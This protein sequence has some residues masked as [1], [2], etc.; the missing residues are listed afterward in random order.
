MRL[1]LTGLSAITSCTGICFAN[2]M[3]QYCIC[4]AIVLTVILVLGLGFGIIVYILWLLHEALAKLQNLI[5]LAGCCWDN[6]NCC[7]RL[8]TVEYR[9]DNFTYSLYAFALFLLCTAFCSFVCVC[10][11]STFLSGWDPLLLEWLALQLGHITLLLGW[12][13]LSLS[14]LAGDMHCMTKAQDSVSR[15]ALPVVG[16]MYCVA[17]NVVGDLYPVPM[18]CPVEWCAGGI[19]DRCAVVAS[20]SSEDNVCN[21]C[22]YIWL[23]VPIWI[24]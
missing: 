4:M 14:C 9:H 11:Q 15:V 19:D 8:P 20:L 21:A 23:P 5:P 7:P 13:T 17:S 24:G 22:M 1:T 3:F 12:S 2:T 6:C 18:R 16:I 10:S